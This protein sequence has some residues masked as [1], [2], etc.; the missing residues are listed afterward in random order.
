MQLEHYITQL[1]LSPHFN[2]HFLSAKRKTEIQEFKPKY[3]LTKKKIQPETNS[4]FLYFTM[5]FDNVYM[6]L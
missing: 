4:P 6:I 2:I 1:F 5:T 3:T